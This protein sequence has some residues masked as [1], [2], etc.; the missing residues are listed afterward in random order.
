MVLN[1][2]RGLALAV[3]LGARDYGTLGTLIVLQQYLSYSALG[4]REG[5]AIRLARAATG[6]SD[7]R[8]IYSS[9]LCWGLGT[10]GLVVCGFAVLHF[11]L[12]LVPQHFVLI[13]VLSL[14][15]ILN[16][17]LINI[18]R[19]ENRLAKVAGMEFV[20]HGGALLLVIA[21]WNW[22]TVNAALL[23]LLAALVA[24][25]LGYLATMRTVSWRAASWSTMKGLVRIGLPAAIF[26]AVVVVFNSCF[27]L[28][29]NAMHLGETIGHVVLAS[30][31]S[32]MLLFGLNTVSWA[33]ASKTMSRLYVPAGTVSPLRAT[34]IAD[35]FFRFGVIAAVLLALCAQPLL[36]WLMPEYAGA[37][38]FILYFC[39]FQSYTL[40][41]FGESNFLN[42]NSRL[43]PVLAGYLGVMLALGGGFLSDQ[44]QFS[45]IVRL[46]VVL[47]FVL[48]LCIAFY[49]KR[50]GFSEGR[51]RERAVAL[52][53]P[54]SCMLADLAAGPAAVVVVC[55]VY[56]V[57]NLAV[58]RERTAA[59]FA[60]LFNRNFA[61]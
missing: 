3:I 54:I 21:C 50:L 56:L 44:F 58:H 34:G 11:G 46:G 32:V 20:Y 30:N 40:L 9:A 26:S 52:C 31:I 51:F 60:A 28:I 15:S 42:V 19:Y 7:T 10:G 18:A 1:G 17:I 12:K 8:A 22:L 38:R 14:V 53:F 23:C 43:P 49:A 33:L 29:A 57:G 13:G 41:L 48:A 61:K 59:L 6:E 24:S 5:V 55:I 47:H 16:E 2:V 45:T 37:A 25:L 35:V 39:L 27:V 4:M 36:S